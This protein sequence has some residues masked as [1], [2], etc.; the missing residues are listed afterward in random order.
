MVFKAIK[1]DKFWKTIPPEDTILKIKSGFD[2]LRLKE[3]ITKLKS[4]DNLWS[5]HLEIPDLRIMSNGKGL[6][7]IEAEASAYSEMVERIS[8]GME[9]GI[10]IGAFRQ[11]TMTKNLVSDITNFRY[12]NGYKWDH[13]NNV[14]NAVEAECFLRDYKF[15][16]SQYAYLKSNSEL[17]KH[18]VPGYSLKED[19]E[20][21]IPILFV[22]WI[23]ATNGLAAGNTLEEAIIQASCEIFERDAMIKFFR[24]D[25]SKSYNISQSSIKNDTIQDIIK[26]FEDNNIEVIIKYIGNSVYPVYSVITFNKNLTENHIGYNTMKAGSSF[27]HEEA[28]L[29][30][31]TERMQGT[32]FKQEAAQGL[33]NKDMDPDKYMSMFFRGICP[34]NLK[35]Y[36]DGEQKPFINH[37]LD[38]TREEIDN[39]IDIVTELGTDLIFI[40][41]THPVFNM[42]VVRVVIP[43]I[44]DFIKWWDQKQVT[45]NLI[46]NIEPEEDLYEKRLRSLLRSFK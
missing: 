33:I 29:R 16:N 22:R 45:F 7:E 28:I 3:T 10:H 38:S 32:S 39:C 27:N 37:K 36:I 30:C 40:N 43:G 31:F 2:K 25:R 15:T 41:H 9:A 1:R 44:S 20:V 14:P 42:P 18:W 11:N 17:L 26:Y 46:G 5:V 12:M 19:K 4:H 21:Y 24:A 23:S 13:Q 8:A 6:S 34:F 35:E